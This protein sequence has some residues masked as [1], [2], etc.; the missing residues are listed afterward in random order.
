MTEHDP[1]TA[2][3]PRR[4]FLQYTGSMAIGGTLLAACAG[5]GSGGPTTNSNL[6][7]LQQWHHHY[8]ETGTHEAVLRY[9]KHSTKPN[10]NVSLVPDTRN[11]Y[12]YT[13]HAALLGCN[14]THVVDMP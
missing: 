6:P 5:T 2:P 3:L 7:T 13:V 11:D 4:R 14:A 1:F 12:P 8:S 10:V 9:A